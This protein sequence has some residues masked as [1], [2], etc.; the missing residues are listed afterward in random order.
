VVV[1][2]VLQN[3]EAIDSDDT[4]SLSSLGST[5]RELET[6][7]METDESAEDVLD[8]TLVE[9]VVDEDPTNQHPHSEAASAALALHLA[10]RSYDAILIQEPWNNI[11][12][13]EQ[14]DKTVKDLNKAFNIAIKTAC[15]TTFL[16]KKTKP[17]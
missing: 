5:I 6:F 14:L 1:E 8:E 3:E 4:A 13:T 10:D 2:N 17:Y 12:N 7:N 11:K 15:P 9:V 16:K